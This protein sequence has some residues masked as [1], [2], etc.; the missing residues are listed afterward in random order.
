VIVELAPRQGAVDSLVSYYCPE[1]VTLSAEK[2]EG[3]VSEP[4]YRSPRPLYG[5]L[6]LGTGPRVRIVLAVDEVPGE[7]PRIFIDRNNNGDLADDGGGDWTEMTHN[8]RRLK[9]AVIEVPYDGHSIPYAFSFYRFTDKSGDV[10]YYYRDSYREGE[11]VLGGRPCK[12]ALL[13]DNADGRFD[14]LEE[15]VLL[16]DL[17]RDGVLEGKRDSAEFHALDK[18]FN[19]DGRVWEVV[20][21]SPDG[22]RLTIRPSRAAVAA[23]R[24]L[25]PGDPAPEFAGATLDGMAFDLARER[26]KSK[27]ILL[28]FWASWCGPCRS[29]Y[30]YLRD[31]HA[32]YKNH[33]L[34]IAG[35]NLDQDRDKAVAAAQKNGL[36]Y[37]HLFDG[38]TWKGPVVA[39]YQVRGIPKMFLLDSDLKIVARDLRGEELKNK[40]RELLG[41]GDEPLPPT[42]PLPTVPASEEKSSRLPPPPPPLRLTGVLVHADAAKSAVL[43]DDPAA[44]MEG[45]FHVGDAVGEATVAA[46]SPGEVILEGKGG[47]EVLR[48]PSRPA[49]AAPA[50]D[51]IVLNFENAD[52]RTVIRIFSEL[53]GANFII[54]DHV[55]GTVTVLTARPVPAGEAMETLASILEIRGLAMVPAGSF[56]KVTAKAE[57]TRSNVPVAGKDGGTPK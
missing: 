52:I 9:Q 45:V 28:D 29:E 16:I 50:P 34:K 13:D 5:V 33:G 6:S 44:R 15:G 20:S 7:A 11:L 27:Y 35:I 30:P 4:K 24:Y 57:G 18:P 36:D 38:Q 26:G 43:I 47:R 25:N 22:T 56:V 42:P 48:L 23:R 21:V 1:K 12:I 55:R 49:A 2:P 8:V 39:L 54:D 53:T 40:L 46:I 37:P 14:D 51:T 10:I 19:L 17:N 31:A 41:P 3:V 32:R